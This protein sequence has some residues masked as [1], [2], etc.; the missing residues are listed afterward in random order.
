[1]SSMTLDEIE[2]LL[3]DARSPKDL[4]GTDPEKTKLNLLASVHPDRHPGENKRAEEL[5]NEINKLYERLKT[6]IPPIKSPKREYEVLRLISAG[7]VA[8]LYLATAT[9]D[10]EVKDYILKIS[11]IPGGDKI[12]DNEQRNLT[13]LLSKAGT[14][15]YSRYLPIFVESF[16][17]KDKIQ[18]R[19]NVFVAEKGFYTLEEI[20][21]QHPKLEGRHLAWIFK[22]MLTILGFLQKH[23]FVHGAFLPSHVRLD[24]ENHG[25][26]LVGWGHSVTDNS[27]IKTISL[28]YK[29]WYPKEVAAKKTATG[30]TDLFMAAKCVVYLAG[31]DPATGRM[32]SSVPPKI[33]RFVRSCLLEGQKMRPNDSWKLFE[34]FDEMLKE[35]YGPPK[36]HKLEMEKR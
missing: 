21:A 27:A 17:A 18:K 15:T 13:E 10:K 28:K 24:V 8:D 7:D 12:L 6:P 14:S 20:H 26:Q 30:E 25:L 22:R 31:G 4:F 11:R 5:F 34:E 36:F 9:V 3:R 33:Q 29:D 35:M 32:P 23:N 2:A 1:M 16:L 19:I